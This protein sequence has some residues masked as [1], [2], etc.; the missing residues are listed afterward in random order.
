MTG[1]YN[2]RFLRE[3]IASLIK[4]NVI[5]ITVI[6][7]D[8]DSFKEYNDVYG[9]LE[10]DKVLK[11]IGQI[12][13]RCIRNNVDTGYRYGGDEFAIILIGVDLNMAL[14]IAEIIILDGPIFKV[15]I[16]KMILLSMKAY[17][18]LPNITLNVRDMTFAIKFKRN[19]PQM[20]IFQ[21]YSYNTTI[22]EDTTEN[23]FTKKHILIASG[24]EGTFGFSRAVPYELI[25]ASFRF[26]GTCDEIIVAT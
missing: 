11:K 25:P 17:F 26:S 1:I 7:I 2:Y 23:S 12:T 20:E 9:H 14:D 13:L 18:L 24:F 16:I 4:E 5:P 21:G 3:K 10:G 8:L 6:M 22:I 15:F 19:I